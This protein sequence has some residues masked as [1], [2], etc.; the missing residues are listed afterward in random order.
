VIGSFP[1]GKGKKLLDSL[2]YSV[3][4][5]AQN[6]DSETK[7]QF[8]G[9][10]YIKAGQKIA[11]VGL[12]EMFRVESSLR[13]SNWQR[14]CMLLDM[15]HFLPGDCLC[16]VDRAAMKYSLI[17]RY[18]F[19]DADVME[20][21][22]SL[23][24]E[25][26]YKRGN[27]KRILKDLAHVYIPKELLNRHKTGFSVPLDKWLHGPLRERLVEFSRKDRLKRQEIFTPEE[28]QRFVD[29]YLAT[30]DGAYAKGNRY[31]KIVWKNSQ[32]KNIPGLFLRWPTKTDLTG[33]N[34]GKNCAKKRLRRW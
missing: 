26:K 17:T 34:I 8:G 32:R 1:T 13:E 29:G 28:T 7:V 2:P 20:Y 14:R 6:R 11:G 4:V 18:P 31:S 10:N 30:A 3:Q 16:K 15:T 24:H 22:F 33:T 12:T 25:F 23:R 9:L 21:S 19:L 27:K 5:I